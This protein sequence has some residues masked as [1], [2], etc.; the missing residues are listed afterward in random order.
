MDV[1]FISGGVAKPCLPEDVPA[2]LARDDGFVWVDI[3]TCDAKATELLSRVFAFHPLAVRDCVER[4]I[5]QKLHVYPDTLFLTLHAPEPGDPGQV[6]LLELD[7]FVGV[8]HLVTVHGPL[9]EG[10]PLEPALRETRSVLQRMEAGRLAPES[11]AELTHLI[12]S[13]IAARM[14][15]LVSDLA[16]R[17]AALERRVMK[18]KVRDPE[19]MLEDLFRLRHEL[20]AV[21]TMAAGSREVAARMAAIA[22]FLP[23]HG[24]PYVEDLVDRFDRVR[25]LCEGEMDFL[26]GVVDYHQSRTATKMNLAMERLALIA[27]V[28]LPV[29]AVAS[30]YGMN[31][32][33]NDRS[34]PW[35]IVAVLG[36]MVLVAGIMLRWARKHGWW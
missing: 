23:E 33:V 26:Q 35:H 6:H 24:R 25:G 32:I 13:G 17:V 21:K 1:R 20:L 14:E 9:G 31:I 30:F 10:V 28:L 3:P 36:S 4:S 29:S 2:L 19:P 5:V 22:R 11:P 16:L 27:G 12:V 18:E 7:A 15:Q 8:R 34:D